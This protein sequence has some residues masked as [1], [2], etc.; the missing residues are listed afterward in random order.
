MSGGLICGT[1]EPTNGASG[2]RMTG[3]KIYGNGSA[4]QIHLSDGALLLG[5]TLEKARDAYSPAIMP[6][7]VYVNGVTFKNAG[8]IFAN[9]NTRLNIVSA[10]ID[11]CSYFGNRKQMARCIQQITSARHPDSMK[12]NIWLLAASLR[13]SIMAAHKALTR[14]GQG[15][16][17]SPASQAWFHRAIRKPIKWRS[18][19]LCLPRI[20]F[21]LFY[22]P[23]QQGVR[24]ALKCS[25]ARVWR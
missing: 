24:L 14:R 20:A 21:I 23:C 22:S 16:A 19:M 17:L 13:C 7:D 10:T 2:F 5:G 15:W 11:N 1:T 9:G 6:N 18:I 12:P 8:G 25:C 4:A 3:G